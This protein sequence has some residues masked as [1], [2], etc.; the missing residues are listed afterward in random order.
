MS[1]L[2]YP[3]HEA[4][5]DLAQ[6]GLL[7]GL[8]VPG[9]SGL[10]T[11]TP[12]DRSQMA[13]A[14][15]FAGAVLDSRRLAGQQLFI[16]LTG[17]N[18]DGRTFVPDAVR[19]GHWVLAA[20]EG[21]SLAGLECAAG[22]GVLLSE[23][24]VEAL[25]HLAACWRRRLA[26]LVIGVTGTN[27]KTTTK[28]FAAALLRGAGPVLATVGNFNNQLGLPVTLLGLRPEHRFAV[29]EMGASAVGEIAAL[30]AT[31][32][33]RIGIITNASAAH[34]A[35]FGSLDGIVRGKGELLDALP[36]DGTAILNAD[37]HGFARWSERARCAVRSFGESSGD[38][39]WQWQ[40]GGATG[41]PS[42]ELDG[43]RWQVPLPGRHNGANLV[44]AI[45]AARAAGASDAQMKAGLEE[46]RGSAHR[47]VLL[48]IGGRRVLDDSYNA[49]PVSMVTA[50]RSL[51]ELPGSGRN[52]AVLG[53]MAELGDD[54][55]N[56]HRETGQKL[57]ALALDALLTVGG[58][59]ESLA[60]GMTAAG[61]QAHACADL[62]EAADW[63]ARNSRP[64]D[65]ILVKGSRSAGLEHLLPELSAR[66]GKDQGD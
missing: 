42:V 25:T 49:N 55:E 6:A 38:H 28:D 16:A 54:S 44:A 51:A 30:A 33:P 65:R 1:E 40:A 57:A 62:S 2:L 59:A 3:A 56:L 4:A 14:G 7:A 46:F 23:R 53:H 63:L 58:E 39:R 21:D 47:G 26:P 32:A 61:G 27:G 31:A 29:I 13:T 48:A 34:L 66:F 35:Q 12:N 45:L 64:G 15:G 37:S 50:A 52:I 20:A 9:K 5:G 11:A 10:E 22:S 36:E 18:V 8:L 17:Q 19:G 41:N 60:R 24:P 43:K